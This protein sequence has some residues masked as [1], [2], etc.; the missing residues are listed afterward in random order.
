[1]FVVRCNVV[2]SF[3]SRPDYVTYRDRSRC[4]K[5]GLQWRLTSRFDDATYWSRC[6]LWWRGYRCR[7]T[8]SSCCWQIKI[9]SSDTFWHKLPLRRRRSGPEVPSRPDFLFCYLLVP[10]QSVPS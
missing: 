8:Y 1:M 3:T 4:W 2:R 9:Q 6:H 7:F 5:H 10:V